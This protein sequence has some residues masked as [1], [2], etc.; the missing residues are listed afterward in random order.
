MGNRS[1][2][3]QRHTHTYH[4][5]VNSEVSDLVHPGSSLPAHSCARLGPT[6]STPDH[7]HSESSVFARSQG[8]AAVCDS[9]CSAV[10]AALQEPPSSGSD[11]SRLWLHTN[12]RPLVCSAYFEVSKLSAALSHARS[13]PDSASLGF[14]LPLRSSGRSG[15][16]ERV[17]ADPKQPQKPRRSL[18]LIISLIIIHLIIL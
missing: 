16:L 5:G 18:G 4:S 14:A 3:R 8:R 1:T 9:S 15:G 11:H 7:L 6:P 2:S 12:G 10:L 13:V 17:P